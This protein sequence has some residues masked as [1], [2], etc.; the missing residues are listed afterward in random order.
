MQELMF[1]PYVGSHGQAPPP[2]LGLEPAGLPTLSL[3]TPQQLAA[4]AALS[5]GG[6]SLVQQV[7]LEQ[8]MAA[9]AASESALAAYVLAASGGPQQPAWPQQHAAAPE[10]ARLAA[11]GQQQCWPGQHQH[12]HLHGGAFGGQLGPA[13]AYDAPHLQLAGPYGLAQPQ[14]SGELELALAALSLRGGAAPPPPPRGGGCSSGGST[15][16][17]AGSLASSYASTV[18]SAGSAGYA[19]SQLTLSDDEEEGPVV[20]GAFVHQ[21]I[22]AGLNAAASLLLNKLRALQYGGDSPR[23]AARR[24]YVCGLR[25]ACKAI[26]TGRARAVLLAPD[27]QLNKAGKP[28]RVLDGRV[29][30]IVAAGA[31]AAA[32]VPVVFALSRKR[33]GQVFGSKKRM[34]A[35]AVLDAPEP[36]AELFALT[37]G[38]AGEGRARW[39]AARAPPRPGAN[40]HSCFG[41]GGGGAARASGL[42]DEVAWLRAALERE[43]AAR[44]AAQE[45]LAAEAAARAALEREIAAAAAAAS[46]MGESLRAFFGADA[47]ASSDALGAWQQPPGEPATEPRRARS[48][49]GGADVPLPRG[50]AADQGSSMPGGATPGTGGSARAKSRLRP[51]EA[52]ARGAGAPASGAGSDCS[53]L[54]SAQPRLGRSSARVQRH[55]LQVADQLRGLALSWQARLEDGQALSPAPAPRAPPAWACAGPADSLAEPASSNPSCLAASADWGSASVFSGHAHE[56]APD[57]ASSVGSLPA[58]R[59][60]A[61]GRQP[62]GIAE[63]EGESEGGGQCEGEPGARGRA[64]ASAAPPRGPAAAPAAPPAWAPGGATPPPCSGSSI[65][66]NSVGAA[67]SGGRAGAPA[68][69]GAPPPQRHSWGGAGLPAQPWPRRPRGGAASASV[70]A[71]LRRRHRRAATRARRAARGARPDDP[72][73]APLPQ[74]APFM[75]TPVSAEDLDSLLAPVWW[76]VQG[77]AFASFDKA[78]LKPELIAYLKRY[79]IQPIAGVGALYALTILSLLLIVAWRFLRCL[80][81]CCCQQEAYADAS[82]V[83]F[84]RKLRVCK[85]IMLVCAA[86]GAAMAGWGMASLDRD[87]SGSVSAEVDIVQAFPAS[88]VAAVRDLAAQTAAVGAPLAAFEGIIAEVNVT[89]MRAGLAAVDAF[90]ADAPTPAALTAALDDLDAALR[91]ALAAQLDG[92]AA[93][94]G[95]GGDLAALR[96]HVATLRAFTVAPWAAALGTYSAAVTAMGA[97]AVPADDAA[98]AA[99]R[100]APGGEFQALKAAQAGVDVPAWQAELAGAQAAAAALVAMQAPGASPMAALLARLDAVN[101]AA[102]DARGAKLTA[103]SGGVAAFN[104][105]WLGGGAPALEHLLGNAAHVNESIVQLPPDVSATVSLLNGSLADVNAMYAGADSLALLPARIDGVAANLSLPDATALRGSLGDADASLAGAAGSLGTLTAALTGLAAALNAAAAPVGAIG[106]GVAAFDAAPTVAAWST[107]QAASSG[108]GGAAVAGAAAA[109]A[110]ANLGTFIT[111]A[112]V[113]LSDALSGADGGL[114]AQAAAVADARATV[115]GFSLAA[116]RGALG[117]AQQAYDGLGGN[118]ASVTGPVVSLL[119]DLGALA[120]GQLAGAQGM[121]SNVSGMVTGVADRIEA[122]TVTAVDNYQARFLP[123]RGSGAGGLV[124]KA[125][126]YAFYVSRRRGSAR[127]RRGSG[128]RARG[129]AARAAAPGARPSPAPPP[130]PAPAPQ[131]LLAPYAIVLAVLLLLLVAALRNFPAGLCLLGSLLNVLLIIF[132][133]LPVIYTVALL[134]LRDTCANVEGIA[135]KAVGLKA[136]NGSLAASVAGYYLGGGLGPNGTRVGVAELVAGLNPDYDVAGLKARVNATLDGVLGSLADQGI[137]LRPRA[138][139]VLDATTGAVAA[140]LAGVD[141]VIALLDYPSVSAVIGQVKSWLC[142]NLGDQLFVQWAAA[143]ILLAVAWAAVQCGLVALKA[144]DG[145]SE[146]CCACACYKPGDYAAAPPGHG[147]LPSDGDET[148]AVI[149]IGGGGGGKGKAYE[150]SRG[151]RGRTAQHLARRAREPAPRSAAARGP[152]AAREM[153]GRKRAGLDGTEAR[154]TKRVARAAQAGA[155]RAVQ[156]ESRDELAFAPRGGDGGPE[157]PWWAGAPRGAGGALPRAARASE[158]AGA[159]SLAQWQQAVRGA[160]VACSSGRTA[161]GAVLPRAGGA[162]GVRRGRSAAL[163]RAAADDSAV[164]PRSPPVLTWPQDTETARDVFAF[165]GSLPERLNGRLAMLGFAGIALAEF[166]QQVPAAE[167]FGADVGGVALLSLA[168]TFASI[169]PKFVSGSSL[170]DLHASAT[171]ANL[172]G[173]GGGAAQ[174]LGLFDTGLE[175]WTGRVAMIGIAGLLALEAFTGKVLF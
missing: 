135:V 61:G 64:G 43:A 98:A 173:S 110:S 93:D 59:G 103:L 73:R 81:V 154:A 111:G 132:G 65:S 4:A 19:S 62:A 9:A 13:G 50:A 22:C 7:L 72:P 145:L 128:E 115:D 49:G 92:V 153:D 123:P 101:A 77:R 169:F 102:A 66:S 140:L 37:L 39:A 69:R 1:M 5:P 58:H 53:P 15:P 42:A 164:A 174:V 79:S 23:P 139:A 130:A 106:A 17:R 14:A 32:P 172:A 90:F 142:C 141:G 16:L 163:V 114:S 21:D 138:A 88:V 80:C 18:S 155:A 105:A 122:L 29:A 35:I 20:H 134:L 161:R 126:T 120:S 25:E 129:H 84:S 170:K 168:L 143:L 156:Q 12:Q 63:E 87:V 104:A 2:G 68:P 119:D 85:G 162:A 75:R 116:F 56:A 160:E 137:V 82:K 150:L 11:F 144:L 46:E 27:I 133:L 96:A 24:L 26:K 57:V 41:G 151:S 10:A 6:L 112:A 165:S 51:A 44:A 30:E 70:D 67:S 33:I 175:L 100:D 157:L 78:A 136:G 89:G 54:L 83:L 166:K 60:G 97:A 40:A 148:V 36:V 117:D 171:S 52:A 159:I 124:A 34:S 125:S 8:A 113:D 147:R 31:R 86:V 146:S 91:V 158:S 108:A 45:A 127:G 55:V 76:V 99:Q 118:P 71:G 38:L 109:L 149:A 28:D 95:P 74:V 152:A 47:S 48:V 167:Q 131:G 3:P 107:L 121:V 94:L